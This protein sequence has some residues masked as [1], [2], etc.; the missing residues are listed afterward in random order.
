MCLHIA[1]Y[2]QITG[3]AEQVESAKRALLAYLQEEK[4]KYNS[5]SFYVPAA[6]VPAIIGAKGINIR[7]IQDSSGATRI[8][9]DKAT[10]TVT[11]RGR[12]R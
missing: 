2:Q 10:E 8:D 12:Y 1:Y 5:V 11:I 6:A 3:S 9:A 4:S 7:D